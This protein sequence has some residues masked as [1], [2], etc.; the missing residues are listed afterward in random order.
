MKSIFISLVVLFF[1]AG[2]GSMPSSR[3]YSSSVVSVPSKPVV[4]KPTPAIDPSCTKGDC[5]NGYGVYRFNGG[6]YAGNFVNGV[7]QGNGAYFFTS[8]KVGYLGNWNNGSINGKC[9]QY[10]FNGDQRIDVPGVC[11]DIDNNITF[12]SLDTIKRETAKKKVQKI[13]KEVGNM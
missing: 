11:T 2:C 10:R 8:S 3:S 7:R 1:L 9:T 5:I 12:K 13:M 4:D 6:N